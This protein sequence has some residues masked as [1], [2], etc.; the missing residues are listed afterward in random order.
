M[1]VGVQRS[2][3]FGRSTSANSC[4]ETSFSIAFNCPWLMFV[5]LP[6]AHEA[7]KEHVHLPTF[8]DLDGWCDLA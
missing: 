1:F 6:D 2:S 4:Y 7:V 3:T 8:V 5:H